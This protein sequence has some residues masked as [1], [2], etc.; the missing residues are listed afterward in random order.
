MQKKYQETRKQKYFIMS[1]T[2]WMTAAT[3]NH[4]PADKEVTKKLYMKITREVIA[5][6]KRR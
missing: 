6:C 1:K 5:N 3:S 2:A 4:Y